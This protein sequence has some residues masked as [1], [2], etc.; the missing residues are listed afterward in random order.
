MLTGQSAPFLL[1]VRELWEI[2]SVGFPGAHTM[3]MGEVPSR[4]H[5]ELDPDGRIVVICHHG[6]RSLN[7]ANWLRNQ[8]FEQAQSLRG[9][10][11]A[12]ARDVDSGVAR[13]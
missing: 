1:D 4:A 6:V 5:N 8:G 2:T 11:D 13:Y 10:I 3:P 7:V 9:G 12:W